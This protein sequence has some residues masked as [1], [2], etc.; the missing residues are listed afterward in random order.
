MGNWLIFCLS[1]AMNSRFLPANIFLQQGCLLVSDQGKQEAV[2]K[3]DLCS[4]QKA[5]FAQPTAYQKEHFQSRATTKRQLIRQH[6]MWGFL[7]LEIYLPIICMRQ[8]HFKSQPEE[9]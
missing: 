1:Q 2:L 3:L 7:G 9:L 8:A 6:N 4:H 5:L